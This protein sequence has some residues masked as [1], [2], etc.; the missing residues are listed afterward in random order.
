MC[1]GILTTAIASP[2]HSPQTKKKASDL[3]LTAGDIQKANQAFLY[4]QPSA[5]PHGMTPSPRYTTYNGAPL[6]P[7]SQPQHR[8]VSSGDGLS[9]SR[10][11][12]GALT[13]RLTKLGGLGHFLTPE[14]DHK[15]D[16]A[17]MEYTRWLR[18]TGLPQTLD[19][20]FVLDVTFCV[21]QLSAPLTSGIW[22]A[23]RYLG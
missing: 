4:S 3:S 7:Y 19:S 23:S 13:P 16:V 12:P 8:S 10:W 9:P 18:I 15:G 17:R 2:K 22:C 5:V 6:T 14:S 1:H 21:R 11:A 20:K